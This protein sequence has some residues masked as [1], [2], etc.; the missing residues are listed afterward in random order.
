MPPIPGFA[1]IFI[2]TENADIQ[3]LEVRGLGKSLNLVE[4]TCNT[5]LYGP[6]QV[7]ND[8]SHTQHSHRCIAVGLG[9]EDLF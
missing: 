9:I 6:L 5:Q 4:C 3:F 8:F 2:I 7:P 1:S